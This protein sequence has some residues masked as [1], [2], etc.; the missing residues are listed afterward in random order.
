[1]W[2]IFW[3]GFRYISESILVSIIGIESMN[4]KKL[5][6]FIAIRILK[7]MEIE[8]VQDFTLLVVINYINSRK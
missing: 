3:Y 2:L 7:S 8:F 5:H 1:M 6:L 4:H